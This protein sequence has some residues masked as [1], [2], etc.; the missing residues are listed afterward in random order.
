MADCGDQEDVPIVL[1]AK[2]VQPADNENCAKRRHQAEDNEVPLLQK[3][4]V[5][6]V[7]GKRDLEGESPR[8]ERARKRKAVVASKQVSRPKSKAFPKKEGGCVSGKQ[9]G[10]TEAI[11]SLAPVS[12]GCDAQLSETMQLELC[13][14]FQLPAN[15][16]FASSGAAGLEKMELDGATSPVKRASRGPGRS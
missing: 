6:R 5:M 9:K 16:S 12:V 4:K 7:L 13:Q 15:S 2:R 11:V 3:K 10:S 1:L 14:H 8:E